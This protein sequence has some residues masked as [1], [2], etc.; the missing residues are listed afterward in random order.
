[1]SVTHLGTRGL[2]QLFVNGHGPVLDIQTIRQHTDLIFNPLLGKPSDSNQALL[3]KFRNSNP[4]HSMYYQHEDLVI[5]FHLP[6]NIIQILQS[7]G[8]FHHKTYKRS[9]LLNHTRH[10]SI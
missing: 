1:M 9:E 4:S 5:T 7:L 8:S 2:G 10:N 6:L 3:T